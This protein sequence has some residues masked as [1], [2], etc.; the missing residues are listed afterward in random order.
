VRPSSWTTP[1]LTIGQ[2]TKITEN[3]K[4]D[5]QPRSIGHIT[6]RIRGEDVTFEGID[7][8]SR[9]LQ[10]QGDKNRLTGLIPSKSN[11]KVRNFF[12]I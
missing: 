4:D 11:N 12:E 6:A 5:G 2:L 9:G 3:F 1:D 10:L 7:T 8:P